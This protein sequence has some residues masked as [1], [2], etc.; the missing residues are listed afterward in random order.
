MEPNLEL[1]RASLHEFGDGW[2]DVLRS[3]VQKVVEHRLAPVR[4]LPKHV[5]MKF[6]QILQKSDFDVA[7]FVKDDFVY[8]VV[9]SRVKALSLQRAVASGNDVFP[10]LFRPANS[11]IGAAFKLEISRFAYFKDCSVR[12]LFALDFGSD[13]SCVLEDLHVELDTP[14]RLIAYDIN[15]AFVVSFGSVTSREASVQ[16]FS[17]LIGYAFGEWGGAA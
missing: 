2:R 8:S 1:S 6:P 4:K 15:L 16:E 12:N 13:S 3:R 5:R 11:N 14:S 10:G 9:T 7:T 17:A